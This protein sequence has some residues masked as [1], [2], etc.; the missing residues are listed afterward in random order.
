MLTS[1]CDGRTIRP[2]SAA[3]PSLVVTLTVLS[4]HPAHQLG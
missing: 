4:L 3:Q 2:A 1:A